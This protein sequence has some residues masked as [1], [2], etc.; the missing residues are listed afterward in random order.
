MKTYVSG[1]IPQW[2]I[3]GVN[4]VFTVSNDIVSIE[5]LIIDGADYRGFVVLNKTITLQ[6]APTASIT[7]DYYYWTTS[8]EASGTETLW[9]IRERVYDIL[10]EYSDSTTYSSGIVDDYINEIESEVCSWFVVDITDPN[11]RWQSCDSLTF[12]DTYIFEVLPKTTT[13]SWNHAAGSTTVSVRSTTWYKPKWSILINE[14]VVTYTSKTDTQ[15]VWCVWFENSAKNNS[16]VVPLIELPTNYQSIVDVR[17]SVNRQDIP[18]LDRSLDRKDASWYIVHQ[19]LDHNSHIE[20]Q[21]LI[22]DIKVTISVQAY[23]LSEDRDNSNIPGRHS[24]KII[25][26]LVAGWL[27]REKEEEKKWKLVL[28]KWY[29]SVKSLYVTYWR[30]NKG[31]TRKIQKKPLPFRFV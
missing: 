4:K 3:N 13:I 16:V 19:D 29:S 24:L 26:Y 31:N 18:K 9:S 27:L 21:W 28:M 12:M 5:D 6:D 2:A 15:F 14:M 20:V 23:N 7:V 17:D 11:R 22:W 1:E 8:N 10:T 30:K 25:P